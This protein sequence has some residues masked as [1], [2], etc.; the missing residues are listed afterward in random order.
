MFTKS[1]RYWNLDQVVVEDCRGRRLESK[2]IRI[3]PEVAGTFHHTVEETDRLD[4]LAYKYYKKPGKWWQICDANPEILSPLT[5]L[6]QGPE[7]TYRYAVAWEDDTTPT[8][9]A[10][11]RQ[12][13]IEGTGICRVLVEAGVNYAEI[14]RPVPLSDE[15]ITVYA[16]QPVITVTVLFNGAITGSREVFDLIRAVDHRLAVSPGVAVQRVGKQITI[17]PNQSR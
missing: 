12:H 3:I 2:P 7:K 10:A 9:L 16:E 1:S 17:P 13:L 8:P 11:I 5:L 15:T 14:L 6:G 4:N